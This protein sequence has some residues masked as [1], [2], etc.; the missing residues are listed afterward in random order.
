MQKQFY[1]AIYERNTESLFRDVKHIPI[2]KQNRINL[3]LQMVFQML[4]FHDNLVF[5]SPLTV[6]SLFCLGELLGQDAST[7]QAFAATG[8][9]GPQGAHLQMVKVSDLL[10][11]Y[12]QE[13]LSPDLILP[14]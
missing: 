12:V 7:G 8:G 5:Y 4:F 9:A 3:Q 6:L 14:S 11:D 1:R 2:E 10:E 13:T